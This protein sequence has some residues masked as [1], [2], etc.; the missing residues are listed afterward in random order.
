MSDHVG[1]VVGKGTATYRQSTIAEGKKKPQE[2]L[3]TKT[4]SDQCR[5]SPS[6]RKVKVVFR[7]SAQVKA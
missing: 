7:K 6:R 2:L 4:T 1:F 3:T 5:E